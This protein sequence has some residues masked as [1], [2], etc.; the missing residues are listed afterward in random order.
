MCFVCVTEEGEEFDESDLNY[1][2]LL[3]DGSDP[4]VR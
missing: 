4:M 2:W 3:S 1:V